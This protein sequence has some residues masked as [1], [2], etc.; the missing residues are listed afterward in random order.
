MPMLPNLILP[1]VDVRDVAVAHAEA[2]TSRLAAGRRTIVTNSAL[3]LA[4]IARILRDRLGPEASK[5]PTRRMPGWM[6]SLIAM[7]DR[8][9]RDSKTYLGVQ[10]KY[11]ASSG[12]ALLGRP[13]RTTEK[14]VEE[15]GRSLIT[16]GLI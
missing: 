13:L 5:V 10:R 12:T 7:F 16:R 11:D 3:P 8:S 4:D 9:L 2:L 6:T 15:M 14:V 1:W